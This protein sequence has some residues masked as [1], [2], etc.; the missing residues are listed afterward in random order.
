MAFNTAPAF[1][2]THSFRQASMSNFTIRLAGP[3]QVYDLSGNLV[4]SQTLTNLSVP[5]NNYSQGT[6]TLSA[7]SAALPLPASPTNFVYL[8]SL[9][10]ATAVAVSV[11]PTGGSGAV[12][13]NLG[14]S[15]SFV[16]AQVGTTAATGV[17]GITVSCAAAVSLAYILGG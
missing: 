1:F 10:T 15:S 2:Y 12:V 9:G 5:V 14:V 6:I 7:T 3:I 16:I 11:I 4:Q 13:Q 8:Q 17:T